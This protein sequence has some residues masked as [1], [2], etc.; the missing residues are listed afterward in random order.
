MCLKEVRLVMMTRSDASP[1]M[2]RYDQAWA[3]CQRVQTSRNPYRKAQ[4]KSGL[5]FNG[6]TL[7]IHISGGTSP[8]M[9]GG[10]IG[11]RV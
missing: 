5:G 9:S 4:T 7:L 1:N 11:V 2:V 8:F 10:R 3:H 6:G